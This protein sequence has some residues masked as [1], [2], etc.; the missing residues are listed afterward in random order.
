MEGIVKL[1]VVSLALPVVLSAA[2]VR[3][4]YSETHFLGAA[5]FLSYVDKAGLTKLLKD[6]RENLTVLAPTNVAFSSLPVSLLDRLN[7]DPA[8]LKQLVSFHLAPGLDDTRVN[9]KLLDTL[10][11]YQC[12]VNVYQNPPVTTIS[13]SPVLLDHSPASNG[14]VVVV[15]RV[16][17]PFP[18]GTALNFVSGDDFD[19][20]LLALTKAGITSLFNDADITVLAPN[21]KAFQS[22]PPG[23]LSDL[24]DDVP[25][26]TK[27]LQTHV[28]KS[29][30]YSAY[31]KA[32]K[33][34]TLTTVSG[35]QLRVTYYKKTV[36]VETA[37]VISPDQSV[38]NGV[39][40]VIDKVLLPAD[41]IP[42][43]PNTLHFRV[44]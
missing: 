4:V 8:F 22:L 18:T 35:Q 37:T 34:A 38:K 11:P 14:E 5:S 7:A 36:H 27:V 39:V 25:L 33:S 2:V 15:S 44:V 3:N 29:V 17:Y 43:T 24:L 13:G 32:K 28:V 19:M 9:N 26:L 42:P 16:M 10:T 12:R 40:H 30:V 31:L 21:N 1:A 20:L 41:Y 23:V 6:P